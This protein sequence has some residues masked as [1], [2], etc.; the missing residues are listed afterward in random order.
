MTFSPSRADAGNASP[1]GDRKRKQA[2][3]RAEEAGRHLDD[4]RG[5]HKSGA[6]KGDQPNEPLERPA[7]T[8][9]GT[10]S[11]PRL[12]ELRHL[13]LNSNTSQE[14]NDSDTLIEDRTN[15]CWTSGPASVSDEVMSP[16]KGTE[17][18]KSRERC[19]H[20]EVSGSHEKV[21]RELCTVSNCKK[22][23]TGGDKIRFCCDKFSN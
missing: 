7:I 9:K 12:D 19:Q 20:S 21:H 4:Q 16:R 15:T 13:W 8:T 14:D 3:V 6:R 22:K 5:R 1:T 18:W 17:I 11:E 2:H 23:E 10:R